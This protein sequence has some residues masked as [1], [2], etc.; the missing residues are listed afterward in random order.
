MTMKRLFCAFCVIKNSV[1]AVASTIKTPV[2]DFVRTRASCFNAIRLLFQLKANRK[3]IST[4]SLFI[5]QP[6]YRY[7]SYLSKNI[8]RIP[9]FENVLSFPVSQ[10]FYF[11][12]KAMYC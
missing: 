3:V 4:V 6:W 8:C 7:M 1:L 12:G 9:A 10:Y 2:Y 11:R 5:E